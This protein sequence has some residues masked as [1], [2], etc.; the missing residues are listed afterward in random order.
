MNKDKEKYIDICD[1]LTELTDDEKKG[2]SAV[3]VKNDNIISYGVNKL[4]NGAKKTKSR[5]EPPLK[6]HWI[7]HAERNAI[8]KAAKD[9]V[10]VDGGEM[11]CSYFPCSDC[12]RAIIESGIKK[13]Y[14]PRPDLSHH[15]WGEIWEISMKMLIECGVT[16]EF[17]EK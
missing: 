12:A 15:K 9:G 2:V 6:G 10:S 13:I 3:I 16:F 7:Q 11:Y 1:S 4:P 5:C 17:Y 14:S 8:F